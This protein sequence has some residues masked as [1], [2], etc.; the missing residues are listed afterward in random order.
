M[1]ARAYLIRVLLFILLTVILVVAVNFFVDPYRI[2]AA[3]RIPGLNE[4]KIDINN[5]VRLMKKYN[6]LIEQHNTL[7]AGNSR[8]EIGISPAHQCFQ[9]DGMKVYNFGVPG[10]SVRTQLAYALNVIHQKPI[11]TVFLSLDFTDFIFTK[12]HPPS[13]DLPFFEYSI[14]GLRYTVSGEDNPGYISSLM[15]DYYQSMFSL[16]SL[17]SSAKT[18]ALQNRAAPDRDDA[19]FNP[20][21]DFGEAA[22]VEGP[23][24]LFDQKMTDLNDH[25]SVRWYLRDD[26]GQLDPSFEDLEIFLDMAVERNIK[27][28]LFINPFHQIYWDL[29]ED[30]GQM[31]LNMEWLNE[32]QLVVK[33]YPPEAVSL[34]DF[35]INSPFIHETVPPH[36]E[37][38]GPLQW[39]WEPSHYREQLGDLM[40]ETMLSDSCDTDV[41]FG[42]RVH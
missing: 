5:H 15:L 26:Q 18:V 20:A 31:P 39:F 25:F 32:V 24:A 17:I 14:D 30:L 3:S 37:K 12:K 7:I 9:N 40:I 38:S 4:Y 29:L 16:D 42:R 35:S 36:G 41:A 21:R 6:P 27:V 34:W 2:T 10:A 13:R 1:T 11:D 8:V 33:N 23:R 28:Y 22:R 19:G